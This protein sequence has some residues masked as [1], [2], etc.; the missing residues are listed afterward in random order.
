[1]WRGKVIVPGGWNT[2]SLSFINILFIIKSLELSQISFY[3]KR[4]YIILS[5]LIQGLVSAKQVIYCNVLCVMQIYEAGE[6]VIL[7]MYLLLQKASDTCSNRR[8]QPDSCVMFHMALAV[9]DSFTKYR[10]SLES[11]FISY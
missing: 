10:M 11:W 9:I 7:F 8:L 1:M 5:L 2:S 3:Q 6:H 4:S